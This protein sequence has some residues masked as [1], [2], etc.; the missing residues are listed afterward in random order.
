MSASTEIAAAFETGTTTPDKC[1]I[2]IDDQAP[3]DTSATYWREYLKVCKMVGHRPEGLTLKSLVSQVSADDVTP[4][5]SDPRYQRIR[6]FVC[7]NPEF[8]E[9]DNSA[10]AAMVR[11]QL[12]LVSL[13]LGGIIQNPRE[14]GCTDGLDS[15]EDLQSEFTPGRE[16]SEDLLRTVRPRWQE[17]SESIN[18]NWGINEK[19]QLTRAFENY[20]KR[21]NRLSIIL[22]AQDKDQSGPEYLSLDYKTRFNDGGRVNKQFAIFNRALEGAAEDH[23]TAVYL[24]LTTQ[25]SQ[26]NNLYE[27]I[28]S[29]SKNWNRL[30]SWLSTDSR[31]GYRPE[32]VKVLEFQDSGNPHFHAILFL[33][34]PNDGSM[35]WLVSKSDLDDYWSKWQGGYINDMQALVH[36]TDLHEGYG[37]DE[38]W[39]K[40]DKD[41]DHGGLLDK[42]RQASD[43]DGYQTAGQYLGKYLSATFGAIKQLGDGENETFTVTQEPDEQGRYSDKC[44]PWKIAMYWASR[45][46]IKTISR[47]LRQEIEIEDDSA[48]DELRDLLEARRYEVIGAFTHDKIPMH[49]RRKLRTV[50][51][52]IGKTEGDEKINPRSNRRDHA[53]DPPPDK[54]E[55]ELVGNLC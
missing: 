25:P 22:E 12:S 19:S 26:F 47:S 16:W 52:A 28:A 32:Y 27:A 42:S 34:Q 18:W 10:A 37:A 4:D 29:M 15:D 30:M 51:D 44:D 23:E 39:V 41:G 33:E 7:E 48:E 9:Y 21:I 31:L 55:D 46:K 38:G 45:R 40:W 5:G 54:L 35:P 6:R 49:I 2:A 14:S 13:I 36:E 1:K 3:F 8:F 50:A 43:E 24:T 20:I 53:L 11:P 17:D